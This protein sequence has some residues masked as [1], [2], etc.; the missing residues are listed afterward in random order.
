MEKED[1]KIKHDFARFVFS[2]ISDQ[3]KQA[4]TKAFGVLG[5]L[6]VLTAALLSRL[7]SIKSATGITTTWIVLFIISALLIVFALKLV[8]RVV[9]PRLATNKS[10]EKSILYF[11]D[12]I[13]QPKAHYVQIAQ[14]YSHEGLLT[15][16][17]QDTHNLAGIADAKFSTLRNALI[18]AVITFAW[19]I[20][21]ILLSYN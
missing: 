17:Y 15:S 4:D 8:V 7:A 16:L 21:I 10:N 1:S 18:M 14:S 13:N 5:I 20:T 9:F 3:I 11:R 6:G 2:T 12:I 19:T